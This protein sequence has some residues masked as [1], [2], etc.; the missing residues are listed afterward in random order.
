MAACR[1]T[2]SHTHLIIH[3]LVRSYSFLEDNPSSVKNA[4]LTNGAWD[5]WTF[6]LALEACLYFN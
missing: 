1:R 4:G 2:C 6:N 5:L 3:R